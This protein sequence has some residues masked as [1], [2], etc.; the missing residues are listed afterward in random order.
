MQKKDPERW[1][2]KYA[3]NS[4]VCEK[5]INWFEDKEVYLKK[6]IFSVNEQK[7]IWF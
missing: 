2:K 4:F 5:K 6:L 7:N 1:L 3:N